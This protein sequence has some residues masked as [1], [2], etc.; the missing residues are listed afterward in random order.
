[1]ISLISFVQITILAWV[2]IIIPLFKLGWRSDGMLWTMLYFSGLGLGYMFLEIVFIQKFLL[3]FGN[4]VYAITFVIAV[5][6]LSSGAGSY[7]SSRFKSNRLIMQRILIGIFLILIINIFFLSDILNN[8]IVLP[9]TFKVTL[10]ILIV[11]MP[12]F[13]MGMPFPLGIKALVKIGES[14]IPWAWGINGCMSV[15]GAAMASLIAVELGFKMVMLMAA[16]AYAISM[17]AM[18]IYPE[19]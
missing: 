4:P 2:L 16:C 11:A 15:I 17:L 9:A 19:R 7:F 13:L 5:M 8:L 6:L 1:M 10:S 18:I 14:S 3:F 12:A